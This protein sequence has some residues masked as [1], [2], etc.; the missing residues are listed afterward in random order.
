MSLPLSDSSLLQTQ[1]YINGEWVDADS[2]ATFSVLNPSNGE[3][4]AEVAKVGA[5]ETARPGRRAGA[6][7][8][9]P[10]ATRPTSWGF[11]PRRGRQ[12]CVNG[13]T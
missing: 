7:E 9:A 6:T 5:A 1:A 2:G 4:V 8:S 12:F 10:P 11:R 13:S 3:V